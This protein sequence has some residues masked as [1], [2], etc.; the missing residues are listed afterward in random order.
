MSKKALYA[1]SFDPIT[2]G[3]LDLI[4][5]AAKLCDELTVGV[6]VN[7]G[8]NPFFTLEERKKLIETV[9]SDL[10]NVKVGSF[11]GLLADYV[12][13][14]GFNIVFRGL[15]STS[16]L[17][18]EMAM[19]QMNGRLYTGGAETVFLMTAPEY[20]FVSSSMMKEVFTLGGEIEGL[21]PK[22]VIA[23]MKEKLNGRNK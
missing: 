23:Y 1:G 13:E 9:T 8:K 6:V 22:E 3:H 19:A 21:V 14:N 18:A 2:N 10:K 15:R 5:R 7:P 20:S 12:N 16:D 4:R 11:S 17:D